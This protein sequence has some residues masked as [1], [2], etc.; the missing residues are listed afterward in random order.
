M[1]GTRPGSTVVHNKNY[2]FSSWKQMAN[3]SWNAWSFKIQMSG[4]LYGSFYMCVQHVNK[5]SLHIFFFIWLN[6][7]TVS[8]PSKLN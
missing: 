2:P 3:V 5:D 6:V 7:G 4:L 1:K 8:S